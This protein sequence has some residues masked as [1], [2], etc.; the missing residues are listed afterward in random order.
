VTTFGLFLSSEELAP[1]ELVESAVRGKRAGFDRLWISDHYHPWNDAQGQSAFVWAVLGAIAARTERLVVTTGVTCPT[2]RIHPAVLAQAAATTQVLFDG[3]FQ[4]GVGS[5]EALNE[6]I[7]GDAWPHT[8][9]R[10]EML[11]EAVE[12]MRAL[13]EGKTV[14]HRGRHYTVDA[15]RIYSLPE[16]PVPVLVSGFGPKATR[17]AARIGDGY[18]NVAPDADLVALYRAS[19]GAGPTHAGV[20]VCWA[21][22]P[23]VARRTVPRLWAH[24]AVPGEA[25]QVLYSPHQFEQISSIVTEEMAAGAV[26]A[27]GPDVEAFVEGIRPYVEAGFDE[28]YLSQ[29]GRDQEGFVGFWERELGPALAQL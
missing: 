24:Q 11:E 27:T 2:V 15:A 19:G 20:K 18:L 14:N 16:Q 1:R 21:Q 23:A 6:H 12:V 25:A 8:D 9:V 28:I 3:R 4:L 10:L 5:G 17:L 13:W 26:A 29:I 22:D 7:F